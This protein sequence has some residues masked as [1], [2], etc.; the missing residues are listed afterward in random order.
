ME[1]GAGVG[2]VEDL[3][4]GGGDWKEAARGI[5]IGSHFKNY[6]LFPDSLSSL[7]VLPSCFTSPPLP[8]L[9]PSLAHPLRIVRFEGS[10][11]VKTGWGIV[12]G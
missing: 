5:F 6:F 3:G 1:R 4:G 2:G 7:M 8:Q 11:R 9:H 10:F 12:E